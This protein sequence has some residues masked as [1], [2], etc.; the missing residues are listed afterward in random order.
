MALQSSNKIQAKALRYVPTTNKEIMQSPNIFFLR[1]RQRIYQTSN[2]SPNF[3][4]PLGFLDKYGYKTKHI[5]PLVGKFILCRERTG[6]FYLINLHHLL[7]GK[8]SLQTIASL[9]LSFET[10]SL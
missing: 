2:S 10:P 4:L 6:F 3:T 9:S 7:T 8:C 1:L 5:L